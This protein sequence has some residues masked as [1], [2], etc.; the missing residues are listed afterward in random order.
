MTLST[1]NPRAKGRWLFLGGL[2][3]TLMLAVATVTL[4]VH[5]E[6]F[7]L[8]RNIA[9]SPDTNVGGNTQEIDWQDLFD[10]NGAELGLPAGFTAS[11]FDPDFITNTNGSFNTSDN[12]TFATGSKDTLNIT[13]G[14]QCN[15]DNNVLSKNDVMNSYAASYTH[16]VSGDE[17]LYFALERN[18]NTGTA[19]VAFWF[20]QDDTVNC[21]SPGGSTAFTGNHQDGDLLAVSEFSQ[22][23]VVSTI[24]VYRWSGGASGFLDPNPV[25]SGVD[26]AG[27]AGG[28]DVCGTVNTGTI[29]TPWR[30]SNKQDGVGNSLRVSEFFEGGINLTENELG[31][32]CFNVFMADTRSSTSLTATLFDFSRG[33]LGQCTSTTVTTPKAADG[34]TTFVNGTDIPLTGRLEVRDS[35]LITVTGVTTF[36]ADVTF[37][38]CGPGT[39]TSAT[40]VCDDGGV[41]IGNPV[42]VTASG[43]YVSPDDGAFLTSAGRYCWRAE[44]SGDASVG[45]PASQDAS[46]GECFVVDPVQPTMVTTA[47]RP[48]P[49]PFGQSITDVIA[50]SG[51]ANQEGTTGTAPETTINATRGAGAGGTI[52]VTAFGP[53]SCTTAAHGPITLNVSGD[54]NYGGAGSTVEFIPTAPGEYVFVASYTG[55]TP[56]TLGISATACASQPAAEKVTVQQIPTDIKTRQ[57]W[58]PNDTAT[59]SATSGNLVAGGSVLFELFTN[60]TCTGTA[61][62]SE[63]V[64]VPGGASSA[65][66]GTNNTIYRISTLYT[67]AA[68]STVGRHSWRVTYTPAATDTAHRGSRSTCD[69]E[70]FNIT[71]TNDVGP[72]I[73]FP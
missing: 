60:A 68:N 2:T 72:G 27:T 14:W 1:S 16:P 36:D 55:D 21:V 15:V 3:V 7:Q 39:L 29:T 59:V 20:L 10:A 37:F 26:C 49:V 61:A 50:L 8:D 38:L 52:S 42:A 11:G 28:D 51:T 67:A 63:T 43:T 31:G 48:T 4:A 56:N 25:A 22:G 40:D 44:F 30:T 35:A 13:P 71:Y 57:S 32:R 64:A 66:V 47:T 41:Q 53:N 23:G 18:A 9:T 69:S 17:I 12:T 46:A 45:V 34:T 58:F 19:N 33:Q 5:D 6:D 62:F 65:E 24:Q 54:G 70:A 73:D